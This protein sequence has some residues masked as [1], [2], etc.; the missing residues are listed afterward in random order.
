M[1]WSVRKYVRKQ[2]E[3]VFDKKIWIYNR[4]DQLWVLFEY[5]KIVIGRFVQIAYV[6]FP[7]HHLIIINIFYFTALQTALVTLLAHGTVRQMYL[8]KMSTVLQLLTFSDSTKYEY[9]I[10]SNITKS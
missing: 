6:D 3:P 7:Q 4:N 2:G 1:I 10:K 5:W 8:P 9:A